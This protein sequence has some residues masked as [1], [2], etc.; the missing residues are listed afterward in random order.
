M[1]P[2]PRL[3]GKNMGKAINTDL[4]KCFYG[5]WKIIIEQESFMKKTDLSIR[6]YL[7]MIISAG[8]M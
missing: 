6:G 7:W 1:V 2:L 5:F 3:Q 8:K 4:V